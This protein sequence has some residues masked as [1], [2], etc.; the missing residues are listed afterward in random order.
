MDILAKLTENNVHSSRERRLVS[1]YC[2]HVELTMGLTVIR[3]QRALLRKV[4]QAK[5]TTQHIPSTRIPCCE[6]EGIAT[7]APADHEQISLVS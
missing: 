2:N 7:L 5:A 1:H 4:L 6:G 3:T